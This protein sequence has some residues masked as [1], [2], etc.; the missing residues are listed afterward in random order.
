MMNA[1]PITAAPNATG[2]QA[3]AL[4]PSR[5]CMRVAAFRR[6][7][8]RKSSAAACPSRLA[9]LA[10]WPRKRLETAD[11]LKGLVSHGRWQRA[12][13]PEWRYTTQVLPMS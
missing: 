5:L 12:N 4:P 3:A 11:C 6:R 1:P 2:P 9:A 8:E 13:D 10:A 7:V